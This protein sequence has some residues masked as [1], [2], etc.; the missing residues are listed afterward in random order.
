VACC[1]G[2]KVVCIY[3]TGL[4]DNPDF[5]PDA[6]DLLKNIL[7]ACDRLHEAYHAGSSKTED[8]PC[9]KDAFPLG[10]KDDDQ[11]PEECIAYTLSVGCFKLARLAACSFTSDP[12]KC[13]PL[14][15]IMI[16]KN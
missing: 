13:R 11:Y 3:R 12:P 10:F 5:P 9:G 14:P 7:N 1:D 16:A 4:E 15:E 2:K 8:C 6:N